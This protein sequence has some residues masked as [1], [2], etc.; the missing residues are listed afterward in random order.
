MR[1]RGL[2]AF[3]ALLAALL[4]LPP[5]AKA[6][7]SSYGIGSYL[8]TRYNVNNQGQIIG[9]LESAGARWTRIEICYTSGT[10]LEGDTNAMNALKGTNIH[11]I[12][13]L[14]D[15][16]GLPSVDDWGTFVQRVAQKFDGQISGYEILNEPNGRG[17][18]ASTYKDYLDRAHQK[19]K[20]NNRDAIVLVGG[21]ADANSQFLQEL[22]LLMLLKL[23]KRMYPIDHYNL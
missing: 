18:S 15:C 10:S 16:N 12:A 7:D 6:F 5:A 9:A 22:Y 3:V 14:N 1:N 20:A 2:F 17:M 13:L 19:I 23:R 21:L 8:S 11:V 4:V